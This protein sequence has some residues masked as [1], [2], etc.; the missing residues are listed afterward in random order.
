MFNI[1][2][3]IFMLSYMAKAKCEQVEAQAAKR[4][5]AAERLISP[6]ESWPPAPAAK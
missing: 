1:I 2:P 3:L 5:K 4:A 6:A